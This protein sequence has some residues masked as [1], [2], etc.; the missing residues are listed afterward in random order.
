MPQTVREKG[1]RGCHRQGGRREAEGVTDREGEGR[2]RVSQ[3]G[4]EKGGRGCH[5]Q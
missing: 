5:R 2:Q 4:R 1:G 3:T